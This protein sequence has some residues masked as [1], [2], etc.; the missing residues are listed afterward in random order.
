ME[1]AYECLGTSGSAAPTTKHVKV[2]RHGRTRLAW[3]CVRLRR[4]WLNPSDWVVSGFTRLQKS[5]A[6][7]CSAT[8]RWKG[9]HA[10]VSIPSR[11]LGQ[12]SVETVGVTGRLDGPQTLNP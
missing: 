8:T 11:N 9:D 1:G 12:T 4:V 10:Q 6:C 7:F 5:F 3:G 2:P